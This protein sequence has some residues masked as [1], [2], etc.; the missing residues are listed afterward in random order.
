MRLAASQ[1][2]ALG[3][4][5]LLWRLLAPLAVLRLLWRSRHDQAYRSRLG[6][7]FGRYRQ[8]PPPPPGPRLW[9]HAVSLGE[10]RAAAPLLDAL[11]REVP[12]LQL[13][14]THTTPTGRAAGAELLRPGDLQ[15]WLPYDLPAA[16]E[17]FLQ[18]FR[19][20]VGV[21]METEIWPNLA[22]ACAGHRVALL[23]ANAR[24]S[25]RS[26]ARWARW[27]GLATA[28]F[29]A[30]AGAA[31][32]TGADASRLRDLGA[33]GVMVAGNLKFDRRGDAAL[34]MLGR[35]WRAAAGGRPVL[36]LASTREHRATA[37]EQLLLDS[38]PPQLLERALLVLVPRHLERVGQLVQ[39]LEQRGLRYRLRSQGEPDAQ[40]QVWVGDSLGEMPAYYAMADA[41]FIGGSLLPLGGQNL[42]EA[43]AEGCAVVIG[44]HVFNFTH[45]VEQAGRAGALAQAADAGQVWAQ[46]QRWLDDAGALRDARRAAREFSAAHRGAAQAQAHWIAGYLRQAAGSPGRP[47]PT[48]Q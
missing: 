2:R 9:L 26:W 35:Q 18:A 47:A 14:L 16:V 1:R 33:P 30:L 25:A 37:E 13:L 7:R 5:T 45:A 24:L 40:L 29:G 36:V 28:A 12:Q 10:T 43:C 23:L 32:Q 19:P 41:A 8:A 17:R 42:I 38:L 22:Q 11:R 21:L 46:L 39:L 6:E 44:P 48:P 15:A 4:Y 20:Q 27:P 34:R 3:L 31:A